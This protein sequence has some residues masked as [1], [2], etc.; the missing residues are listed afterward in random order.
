M[1]ARAAAERYVEEFVQEDGAFRQ[2]GLLFVGPPGH[3]QDPPRRRASCAPWS[4]AT[5][6]AGVRRVHLADPPDPVHLRPRL[7]GVEAAGPRSAGRRRAA[8]PRRARRP[9][10]DPLGARHPLPDHQHPLHPPAADAVHH[11]LPPRA[12]RPRRGA[13]RDRR[14]GPRR[15][16]AGATPRRGPG[17]RRDRRSCPPG[18][19]PCSSAGSTRWPS[20]WCSTPSRT[21]GASTRCTG[22]TCDEALRRRL[23]APRLDEPVGQLGAGAAPVAAVVRG[24]G[25]D[26]ARGL[27]L[28]AD[29]GG[30]PAAH[31]LERRPRAPAAGEPPLAGAAAGPGRPAGGLAVVAAPPLLL[32]GRGPSASWPRPTAR[33]CPAPGATATSSAPSACA[34]SSAGGGS[35]SGGSSASLAVFGILLFALGGAALSG[36]S[37]RRWAAGSGGARRR[38][39]SAAAAR[40]RSASWRWSPASGS[41]SRR[42]TWRATAP[43]SAPPRAGGSPCS[44]GAWAR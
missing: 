11:Q 10:A 37:R 32:S 7:A 35:T 26:G 15:S 2:S 5:G 34:T 38:W 25:A 24:D 8:R 21:S 23:P 16:T 39:G 30:E 43:A 42:P 6:C 9:A 12:G 14:S 18:S 29:R 27:P 4:S 36:C 20:R 28:P 3:R 44:A 41:P 19:P 31:R 22:R 1:N 17:L 40:C 33:P 13:E